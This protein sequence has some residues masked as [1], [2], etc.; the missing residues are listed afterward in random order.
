MGFFLSFFST[1][2]LLIW[3]L[4]S[5]LIPLLFL[6]RSSCV[7]PRPHLIHP[8]SSVLP[9]SLYPFFPQP[10]LLQFHYLARTEGTRAQCSGDLQSVWLLS[11]YIQL[12]GVFT[13]TMS[14][15]K[16]HLWLSAWV[17]EYKFLASGSLR[18]VAA[19]KK[20]KRIS[21]LFFFLLRKEE[22]KKITVW[23]DGI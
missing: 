22:K 3:L 19:V 12:A 4:F 5:R 2:T 9:F 17:V 14:L 23:A 20:K 13:A 18:F 7:T 21:V 10:L 1:P 6:G 8:F 16:V 15:H 11:P